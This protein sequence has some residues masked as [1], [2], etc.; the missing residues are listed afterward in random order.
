MNIRMEHPNIEHQNAHLAYIFAEEI[1]P[2]LQFNP[3]AIIDGL[4]GI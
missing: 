1:L 4:T 2:N 3:L